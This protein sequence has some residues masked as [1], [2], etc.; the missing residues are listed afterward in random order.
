MDR[1]KDLMELVHSISLE[2]LI[3]A[4][5]RQS[6]GFSRGSSAFRGVT[7]HPTGRW[8]ARIGIPGSRHIYLGLFN[9]EEMAAR[10]YDKS[11]VRLRGPGAA[12]NFGLADYRTDLADYHKMQQMVLR[13]DKDWAKSMVGSAEFEEWIKTGEGRSCCM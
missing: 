11:L 5:R 10:N 3:M 12:T 2:E 4:V 7:Y 9:N 13:A 8:E 6:Q 1:Y